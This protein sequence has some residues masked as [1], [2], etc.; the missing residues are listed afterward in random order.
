V[1]L[2]YY[3]IHSHILNL[4]DPNAHT[5]L[6]IGDLFAHKR[7]SGSCTS[8]QFPVGSSPEFLKTGPALLAHWEWKL[9]RRILFSAKT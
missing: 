9:I 5:F 1:H 3:L 4:L 6:I 2:Q 7:L 8:Q